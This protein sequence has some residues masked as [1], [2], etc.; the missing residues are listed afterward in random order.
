[1]SRIVLGHS[2]LEVVTVGDGPTLVFLHGEDGLQW[3]RPIVDELSHSFRVVA[4]VA[5]PWDTS[6]RPHYIDTTRDLALVYTELLDTLAGPV[7]VVGCSFGGWLAAELAVLRPAA[8]AGLV[9]V[10]PTGVKLGDREH[11]DFEDVW[12]ADYADLPGILYSSAAAAPDIS[13]LTDAEY[14]SL[15]RADEAMARYAWKPYMYD[16]ILG[17]LLRRICVPTMVVHGDQDHFV[18]T[19]DYFERYA[20]LIGEGASVSVIS[21]VGHRVE[22]E[23]PQELASVVSAFLGRLPVEAELAGATTAR[24]Q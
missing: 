8:L 14:L 5:P 18:T 19:S 16:P 17:H 4:P 1:M 23:A 20:A 12:S 9:L 2:E 6:V 15:A 3:S 24:G 10:A 21:G 11:R 22:E 13:G 7:V